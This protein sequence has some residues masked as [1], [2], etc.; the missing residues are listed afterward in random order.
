[1]EDPR[2]LPPEQRA[3]RFGRAGLTVAIIIAAIILV[4][5]VGRNLWHARVLHQEERTGVANDA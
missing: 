1:M 4:I 2:N 3:R 5:F